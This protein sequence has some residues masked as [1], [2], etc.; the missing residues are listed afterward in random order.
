M[1][2][3][4]SPASTPARRVRPPAPIHAAATPVNPGIPPVAAPRLG[5]LDALRGFAALI[6]VVFHLSPYLLGPEPHAAVLRHIDL[7]KYGVLLF[8]LVSGYVIPMS[9]ERHGSLRRFWVGRLFRIYPA[10]LAACAV[11]GVLIAAGVLPLT[12]PLRNESISGALAHVTMLT[13]L[14][15][16]R[17]LV[18]VFWTLSYEM[19]F[20]LMVAGL[21]VYGLHRFSAWWASGLAL[22]ALVTGPLLP[23][24]LLSPGF[25][26]RRLTA[27]L[28]VVVVAA[29]VAAYLSGRRP[30]V[31]LAGAVGVGFVLLPAVNGSPGEFSTIISSWQALL[32]LA[33]MF[34]GTVIYHAQYGLIGRRPT[35]VALLAVTGCVIGAHWIHLRGEVGSAAGL[36]IQRGMWVGTT[37]AVAL[38]F[39]AAYTLRRCRVPRVLAWLGT[40]SYSVY[41]LHAIVLL[42]F[43]RHLPDA[44][45]R[46]LPA[47]VAVAA[48]F[49]AVVLAASWLSYRLVERPTQLLGRRVGNVL[50]A[51]WPVPPSARAGSG[52][53]V[54]PAPATPVALATPVAGPGSAGPGSAGPADA[55]PARSGSRR[56]GPV[57]ADAEAVAPEP[58]GPASAD[59]GHAAVPTSGVPAA[60]AASVVAPP[61]ESRT[62]QA[63]PFGQ[64]LP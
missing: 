47:R 60:G 54:V 31:L 7:G 34:A 18:R 38:T 25:Q 42:V 9:L 15:G 45:A 17:G 44:W 28:F 26:S 41:L 37:V 56:G 53:P 55:G 51:R 5:W 57:R 49:V 63:R 4:S 20:Y 40:I 22:T 33:V 39:A 10:F 61:G 11:A 46:P 64:R 36:A 23:D 2:H 19:T 8:F 43:V 13:D 58:T 48:G 16:V 35:A 30:A 14:L 62:G 21:F 50:D 29:S 12:R 32:M 1:T 27:A 24:A 3:R 59:P 6:V 52:V